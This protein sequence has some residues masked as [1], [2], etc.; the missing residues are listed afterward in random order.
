MPART[1]KPWMFAVAAV[2]AP[3][4]ASAQKK[5]IGEDQLLGAVAGSASTVASWIEQFQH[6]DD[7]QYREHI[8][9][10]HMVQT[11]VDEGATCSKAVEAAMAGR[12]PPGT[13]V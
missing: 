13:P 12:V 10:R 2:A 3:A 11:A 7:P 6:P 9:D 4:L 1:L 5:M 8:R